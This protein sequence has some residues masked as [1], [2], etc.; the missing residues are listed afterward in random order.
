MDSGQV[1]PTAGAL[2]Y[3]A[4]ALL[5]IGLYALYRQLLPKPLP[6]ITYNAASASTLLGDAPDMARTIKATGEFGPWCAAQIQKAGAPLCQVF[7]HPFSKPW[8]L[9]ADFPEAYDILARRTAP[10]RDPDFDKSSIILDSMRCMGSFHAAQGADSFKGSRA[11]VHDLMTPSFLHG[12]TGP[13][14][15]TKA[16]ELVNLLDAKMDLAAGRPFDIKA[17]LDCVAMDVMLDFAFAKN[18]SRTCLHLQME[19]ISSLTASSMPGGRIDEPVVFPEAPIEPF[20][21]AVRDAPGII[22]A[23]INSVLP[24]FNFWLWKKQAWY[25]E[26]FAQRDQ[27]LREQFVKAIKTYRDGEARCATEHMLMREEREAEKQGRSP[28]L[29]ADI[30]INELFGQMIA[31]NHTTGGALGWVIKYLTSYS[32]LQSK[33]R[34]NLYGAL[35]QALAEG[36]FPTFEELRRARLP[37][38]DAFIEETLRLNAVPVTREAIRDTTILG[39]YIPKG[40]QVIIISNGPG[41]VSPPLPV[42]VSASDRTAGTRQPKVNDHWDESRDLRA[43]DPERWLVRSGDGGADLAFHSAAGPQLVF[44][45]GVRG[46]WGKKLAQMEVRTVVAL[47]VWHFELLQIPE[48]LTSNGATE[49]VARR[50]HNVFVRLRKITPTQGGHA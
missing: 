10:S 18:Y 41:F 4:P 47:L 16:V 48:S 5:V 42:S 17:D 31:G 14:I 1:I 20:I 3:V 35:P 23:L 15:H 24:Q 36:R 44:G 6:G 28:E 11:L 30:L 37:Y 45:H 19:I 9:L 34:E 39:R 43:F 26:I 46:C 7:V 25:K 38:L 8:I 29:E 21:A 49:G 40:C 50:P 2:V 32:H 27:V 33:V 13:S 22:E 12:V